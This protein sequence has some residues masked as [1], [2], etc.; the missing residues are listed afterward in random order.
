MTRRDLELYKRIERGF[1]KRAVESPLGSHLPLSLALLLGFAPI[2]TR[3]S[4]PCV[5]RCSAS[6]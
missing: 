6:T 4:V 2:A 5:L 3:Y 1:V